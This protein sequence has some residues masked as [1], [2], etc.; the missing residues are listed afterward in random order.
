MTGWLEKESYEG[1]TEVN[2]VVVV[3]LVVATILQKA[4]NREEWRKLVVKSTV[5]PQRSARL[6]DL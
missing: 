1:S 6:R 3:E 4:E 2:L 5:L